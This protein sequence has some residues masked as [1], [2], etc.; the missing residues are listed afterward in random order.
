M[1]LSDRR[2]AMNRFFIVLALLSFSSIAAQAD[3]LTL[4]PGTQTLLVGSSATI[5]VTTVVNSSSTAP[6]YSEIVTLDVLSGPDAGASTTNTFTYPFP[7]GPVS[8]S[9][10]FLNDGTAGTDTIDAI[11]TIQIIAGLPEDYIT[12]N[13]VDVTWTGPTSTAMPEPSSL[14]LLVTGIAGL[15]LFRRG[16]WLRGVRTISQLG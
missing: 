5:N 12:S 10:G 2:S 14:L 13:T 4:T 15:G 7:G 8:F 1:F 11:A 9:D 3:S 6:P 16:K